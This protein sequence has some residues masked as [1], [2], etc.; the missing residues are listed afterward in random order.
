IK[1]DMIGTGPFTLDKYT[2]SVGFV[3]RRNPDY[4]EKGMPFL[5]TSEMPIIT[6]YPQALAQLKAGNLYTYPVRGE[7]ILATKNDVPDLALY[8][9]DLTLQ[10]SKTI[11]GWLPAGKSP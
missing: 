1:S 2:P 8:K 5:E 3:F 11:F 4:Y 7:D 9:S 10:T 6:D